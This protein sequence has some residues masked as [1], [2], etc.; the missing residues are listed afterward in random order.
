MLMILEPLALVFLAVV[1]SVSAISLAL[2]FHILALIP[3]AVLV[4]SLSLALR[5][6]CHQFSLILSAVSGSTVAESDFLG[7]DMR[8]CASQ[9]D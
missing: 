2:A 6:A 3:V 4:G 9:K 1:E 7:R 8:C 5:F